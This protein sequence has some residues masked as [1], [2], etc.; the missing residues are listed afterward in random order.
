M[1]VFYVLNLPAGNR[2]SVVLGERYEKVFAFM[3][4]MRARGMAT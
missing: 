4:A 2:C 3:A 1:N